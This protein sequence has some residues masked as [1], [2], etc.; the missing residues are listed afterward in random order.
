MASPAAD[1]PDSVLGGADAVDEKPAAKPEKTE[2][3]AKAIT[4]YSHMNGTVVSLENVEDDVFS[5]KL[6]G[7]GIAVEPS[8]GRLYSPCDGRI[9]SIF[10]TKHAVNL[11]SDDGAEI[12]LHI[13]I[14]TVK[15]N[16]KYFEAHVSEGQMVKRGEVLITFDMGEIRR[17]GYKLTTPMIVCNTD[18]YSSF[19]VLGQGNTAAGDTLLKIN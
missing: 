14:D 5:Q 7:G 9:E 8:D 13:G 2:D 12:L 6:L 18:D 16:G 1:D 19:E 10:D 11:I 3:T 15:L 4:L 17:A